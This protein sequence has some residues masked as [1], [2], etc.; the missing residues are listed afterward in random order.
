MTNPARHRTQRLRQHHLGGVAGRA[1]LLGLVASGLLTLG[2]G[3]GA[4]AQGQTATA[5][6]PARLA[7]DIPAQD[8]N[9]AIL[10]FAQKAGVR[11]FFDTQRLGGR[12]SS[13][14]QG[15]FSANEALDRLLK[16]TGLTYR[17]TAPNRV[18]IVDPTAS[19][20]A[21][22]TSVGIELDTIDVQAD[23]NGTVGYVATAST[24]GTKTDTPLIETPQSVTV[25]TRQEL[26]D[27]NVQTL[28]EA[29]AYTPGVR[30]QESGYDPRFDSF[31]VR[32]FDVTYN[33]I[34]R[35]GLRL[36]GANMSIFK[37]EPYGVDSITV[38]RGPSS[39]LYGLGSPGGLVDITSKRP[40][41]EA[42]GEVEVQGGNYDWWQ[43]Q[44]DIGGP[45]DKNGEWLYRLTGVLRDA[46]APNVYNGGTN[47]MTFIAPALTW[48]PSDDTR[49]TFLGEYQKSETPAAMP[50]YGWTGAGNEEFAE[51]FGDYNA[52]NQEQWRIGYLAEHDIDNVF[53]VR[54]KL[55]YGSAN[56]EVRYTGVT[57]LDEATNVASRYTGY[58][59]DY[60][61][62]FVVD[63]Q[64]E[65]NFAT[66]AVEHKLLI[67][68]DYSYLA[69][70][71][72]IGYGAAADYDLNS[73]QP[74]GPTEDPA[75]TASSYRQRQNQVGVYVQEQAEFD[76]FILTLSGRQD[77]VDTDAL[78]LINDTEQNIDDSEFTYRAGLT[79][80]FDNGIAPY[81]SYSTS[82][83][84]NLGVD[85]NGNAFAP[86]TAKQIEGGVK[87]QPTGFDGFF[88]ASI[89]QIN[90]DNGLVTD[91]TNPLYQV[92]TGEVRARGFELEAVANLGAGL[93]VRGAYTYLDMENVS[94]DPETIGL[95]PSGQPENSFAFW[96]DYQFQP[97]TKLVGLGVGAGVRYVGATWGDSL[98]TFENDAYTLVD[99]KLSYDFSYLDPKL[100]GWSFQ[101]NAQNLLD[102]EY[103][104]CDVGYCYLGAP[105]T[106]IAGLKYRW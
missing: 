43:G 87:Y 50:Y 9:G 15:S 74:L 32:G 89:F 54:Q 5:P 86:T 58:V 48:K 70:S 21:N 37:V 77:W 84:P 94:G 55:R 98:N 51:N 35:D 23:G 6:A 47:D 83:A 97:G 12:R 90:Q 72:G 1:L 96:A 57:S 14:V 103:T 56:T 46:G 64:L 44:F 93:R 10:S 81:V 20:A 88:A 62:S 16:G 52:L 99:A 25:V 106:V 40:T 101:V 68:V 17:F 8:L 28:T 78:D 105:R 63:N 65:A 26:D 38:L 53:T 91:D 82:F 75:L 36:P 60:L 66:G 39:A 41:E 29:V 11:V 80:V 31:S 92:Q 59:Q 7:F 69:L 104:T 42:F 79:Y 22:G 85:I 34:Y 19:A 67:G 27:R 73:G 76:R 49:I 3:T 71:G 61:D 95:T 33:G 102:E 24:A 4:S 30:T 2:A 100:K 13:A 18:T 45:I